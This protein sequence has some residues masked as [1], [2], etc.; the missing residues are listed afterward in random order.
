LFGCGSAFFVRLLERMHIFWV[1]TLVLS[2]AILYCIALA[3]IAVYRGR[4]RRCHRHGLKM[5]GGYKWDGKDCG[6]AVT[7]YL[8]EKCGA[9]FKKSASDWSEPSDDE[10]KR[11]AK[12]AA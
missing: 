3:F 5:A 10:W 8:C 9:H 1:I 6:G 7:F 12:T 11:Y 2:P 4:C